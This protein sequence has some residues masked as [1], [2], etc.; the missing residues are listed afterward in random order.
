MSWI[1]EES[2]KLLHFIKTSTDKELNEAL[3]KA[4]FKIQMNLQLTT[5]G[6]FKEAQ[7]LIDAL[8]KLNDKRLACRITRRIH[9]YYRKSFYFLFLSRK[10]ITSAEYVKKV[11][12]LFVI[13]SILGRVSKNAEEANIPYLYFAMV[14]RLHQLKI[15]S[16]RYL[17]EEIKMLY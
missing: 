10:E 2:E 9:N 11:Q 13:T 12:N 17:Q 14:C 8:N 7:D 5:I 16:D 4:N 3:K 1:K 6:S 15:S